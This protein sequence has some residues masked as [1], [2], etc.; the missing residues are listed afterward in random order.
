MKHSSL[1]L[2]GLAILSAVSVKAVFYPA[3]GFSND[4]Y[5]YQAHPL[6]PAEYSGKLV[7]KFWNDC[8]VECATEGSLFTTGRA[9]LSRHIDAL[10]TVLISAQIESV[11]RAFRHSPDHLRSAHMMA[12]MMS[13]ADLPDMNRF[14]FID[15]PDY[16]RA[17]SLLPAL[18]TNPV[19]EL[20]YL[21]PKPVPLPT[22][23]LSGNQT[24]LHGAA[25]NGYDFIYAWSQSGGDGS[26]VRL[27]DIEYDW[28]EQHEDLQMSTA[29][30]LY[31]YETNLFGTSRDHGTASVGVSSALN[32][33]YGMQ[34][35]VYN[36][37]IKMISS[38]DSSASWILH[39]SVNYAVSN[40]SPGDV[41]L[42]E[43]QA[44]ANG[45]YCPIEYWALFY[46]PIANAAAMGRI[47][48]EPAG[49]GGT[50][51]DNTVV[52]G[53]I[54]QRST[55]DS[56]AIMVGAGSSVNRSRQSFSNYGSRL[57]IQGWGD[58][59][60]ATLGYGDL[61]GSALSNEYTAQ[62]AGTSSA[63][64]LSAAVAASCQSYSKATYGAVLSP[65]M[66]RGLLASNG[67]AQTFG[68]AGHIGP[69]P[70]LSTTF[71]Q[72]VPEPHSIA[73]VFLFLVM[74]SV[75]SRRCFVG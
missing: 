40:S 18:Y 6:T 9:G 59:S 14:F 75:L 66:L 13:R 30:I 16:N 63:S 31:G 56:M 24:Y 53:N 34:G 47:V 2:V 19:C 36:A 39:D 7:I 15:V 26:Q 74:L 35:G 42:L 60:V 49:N 50:D 51:L 44:Y 27:I 72:I 65:A 22:Q 41:I 69:L 20:V 4:F 21:H 1:Y 70:N 52:W 23:D 61:Y 5:V 57:D 73:V 67:Y 3:T 37:D 45:A 68:L 32:N 8:P 17:Q 46:T 43:Q 71:S 12:E 48:I 25:S 62:F 58:Y 64:A 29:D 28:Y 54:F 10:N 38:V 55:R 33:G 11:S